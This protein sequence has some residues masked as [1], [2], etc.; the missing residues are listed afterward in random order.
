MT[1]LDS[2][3]RTDSGDLALG[4]VLTATGV[5]LAK[6][7]V[8]RHTFIANGLTGPADLTAE[9]VWDYTRKQGP[10]KFPAVPPQLWLLFV[11]DG[12]LR[13]RFFGTYTN[14]GEIEAERTDTW[15]TFDLPPQTSSGRCATDSWSRGPGTP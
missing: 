11:K 9:K 4:H 13:S 7:L 5:D 2:L 10:R 3:P 14:R 15:R 1:A 6:V 12:G 8:I